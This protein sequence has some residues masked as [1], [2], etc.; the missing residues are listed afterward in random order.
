M[1]KV[2]YGMQFWI[3]KGIDLIIVEEDRATEPSSSTDTYGV[4]NIDF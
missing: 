4:S 2:I 3:G 1:D